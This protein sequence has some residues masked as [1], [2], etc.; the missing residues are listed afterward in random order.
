MKVLAI[1][2]GRDR[3]AF[4]F[5]EGSKD[6]GYFA[7]SNFLTGN[8]DEGIKELCKS[9]RP[10][11]IILQ[12]P[13]TG[14]DK[15]T[16]KAIQEGFGRNVATAFGLNRHPVIKNLMKRRSS[17]GCYR[18]EEAREAFEPTLNCDQLSRFSRR[19][20]M[21]LINTVT[22]AYDSAETAELDMS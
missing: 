14:L 22:L 15:R 10:E 21:Q 7:S 12:L 8:I 2:N 3:T 20:Q 11:E 16:Q 1:N 5:I 19:E 13:P 9:L 4:T 6:K 17:F 18:R